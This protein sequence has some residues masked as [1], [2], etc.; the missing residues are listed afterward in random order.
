MCGSCFVSM[1]RA[2]R[3]KGLWRSDTIS[4]PN[5]PGFPGKQA[6]S[7]GAGRVVRAWWI[8]GGAAFN[9]GGGGRRFGG[10]LYT[11]MGMWTKI[12]YGKGALGGLGDA[13]QRIN[14]NGDR[15]KEAGCECEG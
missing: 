4:T 8:G 3:R 13:L 15:R 6:G 1:R 12:L 7:V 14:S 11:Y 10:G 2:L 5:P 9:R